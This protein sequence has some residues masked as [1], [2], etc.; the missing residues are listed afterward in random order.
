MTIRSRHRLLGLAGPLIFIVA[1]YASTAAAQIP[2]CPVSQP[3]PGPAVNCTKKITIFN[4]S[5]TAPL[6]PVVEVTFHAGGDDW[7]TALNPLGNDKYTYPTKNLYRAYINP[8]NGIPPGG[9]LTVTIPWYSQLVATPDPTAPDQ[10]IDWFNGGRVYLIDNPDVIDAF[11]DTEK[12][13]VAPHSGNLTCA[14]YMGGQVTRTTC[15][16]ASLTLYSDPQSNGIAPDLPNQNVEYTFV[17]VRTPAGQRP[18]INDYN[19]D[20]DV[21]YVDTVYLPV[22]LEPVDSPSNIGYLGTDNTVVQLR[23]YL[24]QFASV[25]NWPYYVT[26]YSAPNNEKPPNLSHPWIPGADKA[27]TDISAGLLSSTTAVDNL[28]KQWVVCTTSTNPRSLCPDYQL[29]Q[30]LQGFFTANYD[31]YYQPGQPAKCPPSASYPLP[32]TL[33]WGYM[34]PPPPPPVNVPSPLQYVYGWVPFN[35]GCTTTNSNYP[36][37]GPSF[38]DL[39]DTPGYT[40]KFFTLQN[41]YIK[42]QYN[43]EKSGITGNQIFNPFV[44]LIHSPNYLNANSYAFSIDDAAGN[45]NQAGDGIYIAMGGTKNLPNRNPLPPPVNQ[46][47]TVQILLGGP[48]PLGRPAWSQYGICRNSANNNFP[49]PNATPDPEGGWTIN[50]DTRAPTFSVPCTVTITDAAHVT[51][52]LTIVNPLPWN[53]FI[54][55]PMQPPQAPDISCPASDPGSW[56]KQISETSKPTAPFQFTLATPPPNARGP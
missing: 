51:Y 37:N 5:T 23:G 20:Y 9:G 10:Y 33:N 25:Q 27:F 34:P 49:G 29:Y 12:T 38:N 35:S 8:K 16:Q 2:A 1:G 7:L 45:Q 40:D 13:P 28:I 6:F 56:C 32:P 48:I 52:R 46:Q 4:Y 47:T 31:N 18:I 55:P 3:P 36:S 15:E 43:F 42:L 41:D 26:K 39:V 54:Q 30:T 22:A 17:N 21:S 14:P 24:N 19:V 11:F 44:R 53:P 50:V